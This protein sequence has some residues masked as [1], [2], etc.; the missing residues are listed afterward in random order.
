MLEG[1]VRLG[2]ETNAGAED[3]GDGCALLGKSIDNR[4]SGGSQRSLEHVAQDAEN[5]ME[6]LEIASVGAIG[7]G[8]LPLDTGHHFGYDNQVDD[9]GRGQQRVLANVEQPGGMLMDYILHVRNL[10]RLTK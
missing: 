1:H 7:G 6:V 3:V 4:S 2:L 10:V 5:T 8:S 9:Q